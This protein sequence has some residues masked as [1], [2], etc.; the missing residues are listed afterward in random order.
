MVLPP[1]RSVDEFWSIKFKTARD[2]YLLLKGLNFI[3]FNL[4]IPRGDLAKED[5]DT[6]MGHLCA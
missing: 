4:D 1:Q 6:K 5:L 2:I 3:R